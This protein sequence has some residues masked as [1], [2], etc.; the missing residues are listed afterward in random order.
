[1]K[2]LLIA[3]FK[4]CNVGT[5]LAKKKT[6]ISATAAYCEEV[7]AR[8]GTTQSEHQML[9]GF[10]VTKCVLSPNAPR[11]KYRHMT[12]WQSER[13]LQSDHFPNTCQMLIFR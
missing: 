6:S 10:R 5:K 9:A 3:H 11:S 2:P 12:L 7:D 1:M 8:G 13:A 4:S